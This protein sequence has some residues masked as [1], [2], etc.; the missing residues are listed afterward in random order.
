M[1][2]RARRKLTIKC[3]VAYPLLLL[4]G[5]MLLSKAGGTVWLY[6][7]IVATAVV[8]LIYGE[9]RLW[10]WLLGILMLYIGLSAGIDD[11]RAGVRWQ[12]A[13]DKWQQDIGRGVMRP[14]TEP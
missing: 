3:V 4:L 11:Y 13:F 2:N 7:L 12:R 1:D 8:Q 6:A 10:L 14:F 5:S 9:R